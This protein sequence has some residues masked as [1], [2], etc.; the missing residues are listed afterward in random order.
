[1]PIALGAADAASYEDSSTRFVTPAAE[2]ARALVRRFIKQSA[3]LA[4]GPSAGS[5]VDYF[6]GETRVSGSVLIGN[7]ADDGVP[8][9]LYVS[10]DAGLTW[11]PWDGAGGG[12]GG[13]GLTDAELRASPVDVLVTNFPATQPVS[14]TV[15]ISGSVAVT[16]PLT[17]AE[18]RAAPVPV[19]G[20]LTDAELRATPVPVSSSG[21]DLGS[22]GYDGATLGTNRVT[23][24]ANGSLPGASYTIAANPNRKYLAIYWSID[25]SNT[26][27]PSSPFGTDAALAYLLGSGVA[28]FIPAH[29]YTGLM[30]PGDM[31]IV[32]EGYKGPVSFSSSMLTSGVDVSLQITEF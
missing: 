15:S 19:L 6:V 25:P 11:D 28:W 2:N 14:G 20:P 1:M 5:T 13:G 16:G 30:Y 3:I 17:D 26:D 9:R 22:T 21:P 31:L 7:T 27:N 10:A 4:D 32:P 29:I 8:V 18:L 12:A 24:T 23:I